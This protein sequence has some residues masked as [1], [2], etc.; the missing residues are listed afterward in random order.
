MNFKKIYK[1]YLFLGLLYAFF[2]L[3][4]FCSQYLSSYVDFFSLFSRVDIM[5]ERFLPFLVAAITAYELS[6]KKDGSIIISSCLFMWVINNLLNVEILNDAFS[7]SFHPYLSTDYILNPLTGFLSGIITAKVYDYFSDVHL[8]QG[9]SFFSGKRLVPIMIIIIAIVFASFYYFIWD[10]FFNS[11][12]QTTR[13]LHECGSLGIAFNKALNTIY[14]V[15]GL[16]NFTE[17]YYIDPGMEYGIY[18]F[19]HVIIPL[20]MFF[21]IFLFKDKKK[22]LYIFLLILCGFFTGNNTTFEYVLLFSSFP[23]F[24][25]HSICVG[26]SSLLCYIHCPDYWIVLLIS[27]LYGLAI[28]FLIGK[29][30][31]L[32]SYQE[33][34]AYSSHMLEELIYALGGIENINHMT[35]QNKEIIIKLYDVHFLI[36]ENLSSLYSITFTI[37]EDLVKLKAGHLTSQLYHSLYDIHQNEMNKLIL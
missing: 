30:S 25:F 10:F 32:L 33:E 34:N 7:Y 13:F 3:V 29:K 27:L 8:P 21:I 31:P 14:I 4:S 17:Y 36:Q 12:L 26:L 9:L 22:T 16:K 19:N 2:I 11:L 28:Y 35:F 24:L 20:I 1:N 37:E 18:L 6:Q 5:Y 15:F 23:F